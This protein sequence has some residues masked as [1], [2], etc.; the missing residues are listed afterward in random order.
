[1]EI[2]GKLVRS[3]P[4]ESDKEWLLEKKRVLI[5]RAATS[6]VILRDQVVGLSQARMEYQAGG[7]VITDLGGG[8]GVTVN[9]Q[10][11]TQKSLVPGDII[12]F[13]EARLRLSADSPRQDPIVTS[14]DSE[15]DLENALSKTRIAASVGD[16]LSPMMV[17]QAPDKT[18]H[19][20][21]DRE[22]TTIGR[23]PS[24]TIDLFDPG[25]DRFHAH[26]ERD[27]DRFVLR[28]LHSDSGT[29]IGGVRVEEQTLKEGDTFRVGNTN[30]VFKCGFDPDD[31]N[32]NQPA[33]EGARGRRPVVFVPGF[34]GSELWR[35][36]ER[37]WPNLRM[38]MSNPEVF[39][40]PDE[41]PL[42]PRS[43]LNEVVVVP[44][45][46]KLEQYNRLGNFL[47]EGLG[48]TRGK[49]L[50]EFPY[51]WRQDIRMIARR[52]ADAIDQWQARSSAARQPITIIAHSMG[53]LVSRY[54]VER[55]G[56]GE[57]VERLVLLGGPHAGTLTAF[58]TLVEARILP[59][60]IMGDRMRQ[61]VSS[62]PSLYQIL[63][64]RLPVADQS[65]Y[66][67][68]LLTDE[69]WLPEARRGLLRNARQF[70]SELGTSASVPSLSIFGYGYPTL[71]QALL[72]REG[73]G[74]WAR[75]ELSNAPQ[76][77]TTITQ[78][79]AILPGS[80]IHPVQQSHGALYTDN[81]VKMRL[82]LE[83]TRARGFE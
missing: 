42:D 5:G 4:G 49:D 78:A 62:F 32:S 1:M 58:S 46:I 23:H 64:T 20:S 77:D 56:G 80:E 76:G 3:R 45:L 19:I 82:K 60:G 55:L 35:G 66:P 41:T 40:N 9:G 28:D 79:S 52:L 37:V 39:Q 65:G 48:Y 43:V 17:V 31:L 16:T 53:C 44:N 63:P 25:V 73:E 18:F 27:G 57:K 2:L 29:W 61:V 47:E 6:D 10:R 12:A 36:S 33:G 75:V 69:S 30:L 7:W 71:F 11:V 21:L 38:L 24:N 54:Y 13:G 59:F 15:K 72:Q 14:L 83:L 8:S 70:L 50:M 67:V 81:D 22:L 34:M 51:D 68:N 74:A 26:V